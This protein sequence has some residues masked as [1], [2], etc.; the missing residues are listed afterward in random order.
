M[1]RLRGKGSLYIFPDPK[2]PEPDHRVLPG[3]VPGE[4]GLLQG[5]CRGAPPGEGP[6]AAGRL[7]TPFHT[8]RSLVLFA[9]DARDPVPL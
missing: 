3:W 5:G 8:Q 4:Q 7:R 1:S 2:E 9:P 6:R